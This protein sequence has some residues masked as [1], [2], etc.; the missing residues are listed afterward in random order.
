MDQ[1]KSLITPFLST[2]ILLLSLSTTA[3]GGVET[4]V[5]DPPTPTPTPGMITAEPTLSPTAEPTVLPTITQQPPTPIPTDTPEPAP[6]ETPPPS[7]E[8]AH[9]KPRC[10]G[11][12]VVDLPTE[13]HPKTGELWQ[14]Y[15]NENYGFAFLVPPGWNL[16]EGQNGL[17][18]VDQSDPD[19]RFVIGYKWADDDLVITRT[20]VAAG[21]LISTGEVTFLGREIERN[22]LRYEGKDKKVLYDNAAE[23]RIN[24]LMFSLSLD[25]NTVPYKTAELTPEVMETAD[26]IVASFELIDRIYVNETYGFSFVF[27]P[28]WR[29]SPE[30]VSG[31]NAVWL[32]YRPNRNDIRFTIAFKWVDEEDIHI[33]RTGVGSTDEIVRSEIAF[34]GQTIER[35]LLRYEGKN[36]AVLYA[37]A[38]HIEAN[39]RYFTLSLNFAPFQ[40]NRDKKTDRHP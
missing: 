39:G 6:T 28:E 2:L 14:R 1:K 21:E 19:I 4:A 32:Y 18:L 40:L 5:M 20:G 11:Q 38:Y 34:L 10:G 3:C 25:D 16:V 36:K 9:F 23:I 24:A 12:P 30:R 7:V 37:G 31:Q 13:P 27:P 15:A 33:V 35:S 26:A 29:Q 17:C 8:R 22:V